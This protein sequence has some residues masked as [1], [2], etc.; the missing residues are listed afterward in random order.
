MVVNLADRSE[1]CAMAWHYSLILKNIFYIFISAFFWPL[2]P[3]KYSIFQIKLTIFYL[4]E[5]FNNVYLFLSWFWRLKF[6]GM[7]NKTLRVWSCDRRLRILV[8]CRGNVAII[9]KAQTVDNHFTA[10]L[11]SDGSNWPATVYGDVRLNVSL[12]FPCWKKLSAV[13]IVSHLKLNK[14]VSLSYK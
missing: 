14:I 4:H 1:Q 2:Q 5:L 8:C 3:S 10:T 7:T 9:I 11:E 12:T 13:T 6:S